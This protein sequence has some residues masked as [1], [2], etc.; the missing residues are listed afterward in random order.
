MTETIMVSTT[1]ANRD[2]ALRL[3][4]RLLEKRLVA[5]AQI[6]TAVLSLY[7]WQGEIEQSDECRLLMKSTAGLRKKIESEITACHPYETPEIIYT[8][9]AAVNEKYKKWLLGELGQ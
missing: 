8:E 5:C 9:M 6:D 3:A 2:D 4:R 1:F 7:W